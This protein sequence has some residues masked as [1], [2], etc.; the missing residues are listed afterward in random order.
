MTIESLFTHLQRQGA[1]A[2]KIDTLQHGIKVK[3]EPFMNKIVPSFHDPFKI[4]RLEK[5]DFL[6]LCERVD[7]LAASLGVDTKSFND[8]TD[9]RT[10]QSFLQQEIQKTPLPSRRFGFEVVFDG[11]TEAF[12]FETVKDIESHQAY[13]AEECKDMTIA[14]CHGFKIFMLKKDK[15]PA[16]DQVHLSHNSGAWLTSQGRGGDGPA[17]MSLAAGVDFVPDMPPAFLKDMIK[18]LS[19]E[20]TVSVEAAN[21]K[22]K[23]LFFVSSQKDK[24]T[25]ELMFQSIFPAMLNILW[26]LAREPKL[27]TLDEQN[28]SEEN[29][30]RKRLNRTTLSPVHTLR[31][32][33]EELRRIQANRANEI[34]TALATH[35]GYKIP[36]LVLVSEHIKPSTGSL[37]AAYARCPSNENIR[38]KATELLRA[39]KFD[40]LA[41]LVTEFGHWT[42]QK[43]FATSDVQ[44][45]KVVDRS[46]LSNRPQNLV[47]PDFMP[48]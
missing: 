46:Q 28:F 36:G 1:K 35:G 22:Y 32:D 30:K 7:H 26:V 47:R 15:M 2:L 20:K 3:L 40:Q 37:V 43:M 25:I 21:E 42:T 24:A 38:V 39:K 27:V 17:P 10:A 41:E 18:T 44:D 31:I 29:R 34:E 9:A 4:Y 16:D 8:G 6:T 14:Q 5:K 45:I 13:R 11:H 19:A 33:Q 12:L 23:N 48:K